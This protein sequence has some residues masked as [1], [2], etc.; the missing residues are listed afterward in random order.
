MKRAGNAAAAIASALFAA[1]ASAQSA[2]VAQ[3]GEC[4]ARVVIPPVFE[5]HV[6]QHLK[7]AASERI[8]VVPAQFE[9]VEEKV[10]VRA[11]GEKIVRIVPATYRTVTERIE[12]K[13]AGEILTE[14]PATYR[15]E[16]VR[17]LV[18][19]AHT[20]WKPGRGL[21]E[22]VDN[23]SGEVLCLVEV[24]DE[25]AAVKQR[26][27]DQPA[28]T[29]RT[30]TPAEYRTVTRQELVTPAT[31]EKITVPAEYRTVSV[32]RERAAAQ[33]TRVAVPAEYQDVPV[34]T[35]IADG[36]S[37]WQPVLCEVNATP[38]TV[39]EIQ[40]SLATQGFEPG[41]RSGRLDEATLAAVQRFQQSKHLATG[42]VTL[43]TLDALGVPRPTH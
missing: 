27:V 2:V 40:A 33:E 43:T 4:Y 34:Q 37:E 1:S 7:T 6:E 32:R 35:K 8:E 26:V 3:P 11:E 12:V 28:T 14:V 16:E 36:R 18:R 30:A 25:Y 9:T 13:P 39:A 38:M 41:T 10:Q 22:K 31:V 21:I 42:G 23:A 20:E 17:T 24:P 15:T 5:T 29:R 19:P